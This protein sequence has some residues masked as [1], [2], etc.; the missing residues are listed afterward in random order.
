MLHPLVSA[1]TQAI[2]F[3]IDGTLADTMPLH[4]KASQ[5][6]CNKRGFD[7]PLEYFYAKAGI[8][9]HKVFEMLMLELKLPFNGYELATEKEAEFLKLIP[10]VKPLNPAAEVAKACYGKIPMALGT[11]GTKDIAIPIMEKI[12]MLSMFE[13]MV[14]PE[15]VEKP[16]PFPDTFIKAAEF[17]GIAPEFCLV[18][19]D[20]D[21]GLQAAK[22]AGMMAV[23]VRLFA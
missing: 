10:E 11:G 4:Y 6:V 9:T 16:K 23:D 19:E 21:P 1:T 12:G 13:I 15:M 18:F 8:P 5:I 2:I 20:A 17:M 14:T 3:D 7:F 22:A